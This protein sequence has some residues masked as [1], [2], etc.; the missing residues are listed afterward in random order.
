[1]ATR[2]RVP[3][4]ILSDTEIER[5][6]VSDPGFY[7]LI[8]QF[9][10]NSYQGLVHRVTQLQCACGYEMGSIYL[11]PFTDQHGLIKHQRVCGYC[12]ATVQSGLEDAGL[13][14][15]AG[16]CIKYEPDI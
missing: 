12:Y 13:R 4:R 8:S 6:L 16:V 9:Y 2:A 1:M 7:V 3:Y 15:G 10:P 14:Y 5:D 11:I